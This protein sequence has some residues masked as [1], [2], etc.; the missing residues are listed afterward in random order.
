MRHENKALKDKVRALVTKIESNEKALAKHKKK[1][2]PEKKESASN[3]CP[4]C[5]QVSGSRSD[6]QLHFKSHIEL[7]VSKKNNQLLD[8][9]VEQQ[10]Y[11]LTQSALPKSTGS[12]KP[13]PK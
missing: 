9:L 1:A 7:A 2:K 13:D 4:L 6:L 5:E 3:S 12:P 10:K 8:I 11:L